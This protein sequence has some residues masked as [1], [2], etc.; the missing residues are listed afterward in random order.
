[1]SDSASN[2][3]SRYG[4]TA[5]EFARHMSNL[6]ALMGA[7]FWQVAVY[8]GLSDPSPFPRLRLFSWPRLW[9]RNQ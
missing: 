3:A 9:G 5:D 8:F 6:N 7:S 2:G 1:M 4:W